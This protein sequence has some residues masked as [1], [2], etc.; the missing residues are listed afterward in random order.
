MMKVYFTLLSIILLIGCNKKE[1]KL[2]KDWY[3]VAFLITDGTYNTEFTAPYDIFQHTQYREGIKPMNVFSVANKSDFITTFEGLKIVPDYNFLTDELPKIDIL[4][5]PSAEHHLDSDMDDKKLIEFIQKTD[6]NALYMT[7]HCD[8]A[9]MLAKAGILNGKASTTF[10][11]DIKKYKESFPQLNVK[12]S[13][14][15]VHDGKYITS[16]GGAKSFEAALYLTEVMYGDTI[17]QKLAKGLVIDW[18]LKKT[19]YFKK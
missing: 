15:F 1:H 11:S 4:V 2:N 19:P 8:G 6:K 18:D 3:N 14:L 16:A 13:V 10:P 5:V 9:F 17:A 7:S 12:D